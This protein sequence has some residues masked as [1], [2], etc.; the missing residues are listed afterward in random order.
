MTVICN[1][2]DLLPAPHRA[3]F[4]R[5]RSIIRD[6]V[7]QRYLL[8]E[9]VAGMLVVIAAPASEVSLL[10]AIHLSEH[11][12]Q[13]GGDKGEPVV[14]LLDPARANIF[15]DCLPA[16]AREHVDDA[17]HHHGG[18]NS[19]VILSVPADHRPAVGVIELIDRRLVH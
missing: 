12:I 9:T 5:C 2:M 19:I 16:A 7:V 10:F 15:L 13:T 6:C 18:G 1:A 17:L 14:V 8:G 11:I 3:L 4:A